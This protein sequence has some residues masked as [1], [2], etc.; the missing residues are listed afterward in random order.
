MKI[1]ICG[2]T[3]EEDALYLN[4]HSVDFA[5][6]VVF[7]PKSRR[8]ITLEQAQKI[9][10]VLSSSIKKVAVVVS[11]T[12]EQ[13]EQIQQA[14]FDYIQIHGELL[15]QVLSKARLPILKAFNVSDLKQ[16]A[17]YHTCDKIAGYVFDAAEPGS[18]KTFDWNLLQTL[19]RDG[20]LFLLA[21]GLHAGNVVKAIETAK[22]DGIDV[23]TSVEYDNLPGKDPAKI[24][25]LVET[26]RNHCARK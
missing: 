26:I 2:L 5:G 8:N 7:Y 23:S 14:G 12:L 10:A 6:F 3:R 22:P 11:P 25:T 16:Y 24:S 9:M 4:Q 13:I 18:G 20:K 15:P 17:S 19:P 21:G 1:K